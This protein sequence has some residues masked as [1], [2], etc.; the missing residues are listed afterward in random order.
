MSRK[1]DNLAIYLD[2]TELK[3][4]VSFRVIDKLL[5]AYD[6]YNFRSIV[7]PSCY[8]PYVRKNNENINITGVVGF[9]LGN[10][11][12][13][14]K[15]H[16]VEFAN[17]Y[18]INDIDIVP[19]LGFITDNM[20]DAVK[21]ELR[22]LKDIFSGKIVKVILETSHLLK[23]DW[24]KL[25]EVSI[26]IGA[27]VIKTSTGFGRYGAKIEEIR[28]LKERFKNT[29]KIKASGG[30]KT[31]EEV[32]ALISAGADIIGTSSYINILKHIKE[33]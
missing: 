13:E 20:W 10:T 11:S 1:I 16:E 29:V 25:A 24:L 5:K 15:K 3:S 2:A 7:I 21:E 33:A 14:I 19:N 23:K 18:N 26:S 8:F 6:T 17:K 32:I 27:D 22:V 28:L 31:R 9:P 4:N 30:I 12:M